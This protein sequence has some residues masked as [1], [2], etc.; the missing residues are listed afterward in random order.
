MLKKLIY[1]HRFKRYILVG[2]LSAILEYASFFNFSHVLHYNLYISNS[3]S[4]CV[5]LLTS[6]FLNRQ[7]SFSEQKKYDKRFYHQFNRYLILAIIN[8]FITNFIIGV[9]N[10]VLNNQ[11]QDKLLSMI[12]SSIWNYFIFQKF[13]FTYRLDD[14]K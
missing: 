5:G 14:D 9:L 12:I 13:I 10:F 6:F 7:W 4:F 8:L 2:L 3:I 1:N 11:L